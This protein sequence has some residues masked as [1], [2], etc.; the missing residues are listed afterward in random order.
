MAKIFIW[1]FSLMSYEKARKSLFVNPINPPT[2]PKAT[3]INIFHGSH[4]KKYLEVVYIAR[5]FSSIAYKIELDIYLEILMVIRI[6]I[7]HVQSR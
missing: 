6:I 2:A 3:S 1:V 7:E 4:L 5:L